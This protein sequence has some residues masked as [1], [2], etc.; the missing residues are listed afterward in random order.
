MR[1]VIICLF[2]LFALTATVAYAGPGHNHD[3]SPPI[4][5]EQAIEKATTVVKGLVK[6]EKLDATWSKVSSNSCTKLKIKHGF[7][8]KVSFNNSK[9]KDKEK[10]TLYVFLS[11]SGKYLAAN[12]T[13]K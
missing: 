13:G 1:K 3:H 4:T 12:F 11:S 10:Q 9:V 2:S 5:K 7:E 8:W 6:K